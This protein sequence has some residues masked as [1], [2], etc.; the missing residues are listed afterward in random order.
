MRHVEGIQTVIC[1]YFLSL[2]PNAKNQLLSYMPL[3]AN[4]LLKGRQI[5]FPVDSRPLLLGRENLWV[6][7]LTICHIFFVRG[8]RAGQRFITPTSA[9]CPSVYVAEAGALSS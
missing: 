7:I 3:S 1:M 9:G 6:F 4:T 8:V 5:I 2:G